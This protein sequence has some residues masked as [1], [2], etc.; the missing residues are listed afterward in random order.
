MNIALVF[1]PMWN[2]SVLFLFGIKYSPH[3]FS[4]RVHFS[5]Y[6]YLPCSSKVSLNLN[7]SVHIVSP[8]V[9][10]TPTDLRNNSFIT[11]SFC[12]MLS[13]KH[14]QPQKWF[15]QH[16]SLSQPVRTIFHT[17][18]VLFK[19]MLEENLEESVVLI[20]SSLGQPLTH[21]SLWN[22]SMP[23]VSSGN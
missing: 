4:C 22:K 10:K 2:K 20:C 19:F 13:S 18:T 23:A 17:F 14:G 21:F 3:Y 11:K 6:F 7:Y 9:C 8:Q 15:D 16:Y 5:L 1:N 12:S